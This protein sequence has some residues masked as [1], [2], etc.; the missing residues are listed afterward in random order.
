MELRKWL[1]TEP[2]LEHTLQSSPLPSPE[3]MQQHC[4]Q[5]PGSLSPAV[6]EMG[7]TQ[8]KAQDPRAAGRLQYPIHSMAMWLGCPGGQCEKWMA[9]TNQQR[10]RCGSQKDTMH[11]SDPPGQKA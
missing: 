2:V 5:S 3:L 4:R 9:P 10:A 1:G 8:Q 6:A 11:A 7:S